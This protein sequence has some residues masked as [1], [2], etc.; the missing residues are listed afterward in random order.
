MKS[1]LAILLWATSP[2]SPHLCATPFFN[3]AVAAALDIE[4]EI[5]FTNQSVRLLAQGV[6]GTLD[7]GP[8]KRKTVYDFMRHAAEHGVKFYACSHALEEHGLAAADLIPE[9]TGVAGA[10]T[11]MS[12]CM[13]E[14][15]ATLVF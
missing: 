10:A 5:Y 14:G 8:R 7:S 4:V 15:W 1:R 2:D 9:V 12:R 13:D 3:A 11:Y 6:A